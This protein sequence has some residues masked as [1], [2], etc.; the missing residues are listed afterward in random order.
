METKKKFKRE[1]KRPLTFAEILIRRANRIHRKIEK[2]HLEGKK[3][4]HLEN[5]LV[6]IAEELE[7]ELNHE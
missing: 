6:E 5:Q 2:A 1:S 7:W 3:T 4:P